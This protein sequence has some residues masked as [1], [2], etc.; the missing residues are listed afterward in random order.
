MKALKGFL[1][2]ALLLPLKGRTAMVLEER[3]DML[4]PF[5]T[6]HT[7][8]GHKH[9]SPATYSM[10]TGGSTTA[11]VNDSATPAVP[12]A[13]T[14]TSSFSVD[15]DSVDPISITKTMSATP[16]VS[17]LT[18]SQIG[19]AS[20]AIIGTSFVTTDATL[21]IS[22]V[23]VMLSTMT[24]TATSTPSLG[25]CYE[26]IGGTKANGAAIMGCGSIIGQI[27]LCVIDQEQPEMWTE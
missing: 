16:G 21:F 3:G 18:I 22:R 24:A 14:L 25:Q 6:G 13:I 19:A 9:H 23:S 1:L 11:A 17:S 12:A 2:P 26:A 20:P 5:N 4:P 10:A 15:P 7:G 27:G 8:T